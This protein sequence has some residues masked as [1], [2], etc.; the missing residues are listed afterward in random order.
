MEGF[1]SG[2]AVRKRCSGGEMW[3]YEGE[4]RMREDEGDEGL[5]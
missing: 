1:G 3:W 5:L 2:M 4:C